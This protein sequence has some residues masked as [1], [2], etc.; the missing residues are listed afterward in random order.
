M[1]R[2]ILVLILTVLAAGAAMAA[3]WEPLPAADGLPGWKPLGGEWKVEEGQIIGRA[4]K[5]ENCWLLYEAK[6]FADFELEFEFITPAP[7]NGGVQFRSHWL[8]VLPFKEGVPAAEQPRQ[9]YGYQCNIETRQKSGTGKLIDENGRGPLAEPDQAAVEKLIRERKLKQRGWNT[10]RVVARGPAL[11]LYLDGELVAKFEDEAY[12]KGYLALQVNHLDFAEPVAEVRYRNLRILDLGREGAWRPLFDGQSLAG[13]KTWGDE[14]WKVENGTVI[15][16]SGPKK[17]EGY[18]ATEATWEDFRVRGS[19][20]M[21][22]EGNFGL[23][24]HASITLRE[25][26]YPL[27]AGVQGEV[28]PNCPTA[29][30]RIYESYQ[31]GWLTPP[32]PNTTGALALRPGWNELEIRCVGPRTTTWLNGVRVID[33]NDSEPKLTQ[34]SFALQLH[35]GGVDG[36]AWRDIALLE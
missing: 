18:L 24:F 5:D 21:L 35:T 36:I 6:E 30:G 4:Q 12:L 1:F 26:G 3:D 23:F 11:E 16:R 33:F 7:V 8:P 25:D 28:E 29:S 10:M 15:G 9:M 13:W 32:D 19:F 27:I 14:D 31:R 17:S 2:Q 20:D 34:G 22:G